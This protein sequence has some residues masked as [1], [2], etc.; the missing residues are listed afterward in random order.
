MRRPQL[1]GFLALV[2]CAFAALHAAPKK[3]ITAAALNHSPLSQH[4]RALHALNR[5]TFGPRPEDVRQV[6]A[7]GVDKWIDLQLHPERINDNELQTMLSQLPAMQLSEA[8]MIEKFPPNPMAR[9]MEKTNASLPRDPIEHAI[10]ANQIAYIK[11]NQLQQAAARASETQTAT[12]PPIVRNGMAMEQENKAAAQPS[13][14]GPS[15]E[16]INAL[17]ADKQRLRSLPPQARFDALLAVTPGEPRRLFQQ[18]K[19]PER[20][21]LVDGFTPEQKEIAI[22]LADTNRVV[23]G[24]TMEQKLLYDIYSERQLQEVVTDFWLNHFNVYVRKSGIEPWQIATYERDVIRPRALGKFEDLLRA[25]ATSPAMMEYLDNAQSIG[26]HSKAAG[27]VPKLNNAGLAKKLQGRGLNENYARELMELH[28]L[29]VNGGYTQQD[30]TEVAKVFTGWT[31][32]LPREGGSFQYM[33][34][35][36]EPG[37]KHVLGKTIRENGQ[38]EG[39]EV[40]HM[41][42]GSPATA[43]FLSRK[44]AVRFVSDNP[45]PALVDAMAQ[46]YLKSHGDIREVMKTMLQSPEFWSRDAY[47]AKVKTPLEYVVSSV[48]ATQT[49]ATHPQSLIASLNQMG[50]PLYGMQPPT[51]YSDMA[52]VW[53]NSAALL[54]RMNFGLALA[55][56]KLPGLHCDVNAIATGGS[57]DSR[58]EDPKVEEAKLED[59]LLNGSVSPKTHDTV[60]TEMEK[61]P[62]QEQAQDA[63]T[64]AD[65][66]LGGMA[67][68]KNGAGARNV[69]LNVSLSGVSES[70]VAAGLLLGSP[71]F[72]RK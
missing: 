67:A 12:T 54:T 24:E 42:A 63:P 11:A 35:R 13:P 34:R 66:L 43:H 10:Y 46:A 19:P 61:L 41:L 26:P 22:A 53:V 71:D 51:G 33:D 62:Q 72:Q 14:D 20:L 3:K 44:L 17:Q 50:M 47:R 21:A 1:A 27:F 7:M 5:L 40:L 69:N 23:A 45:P 70:A 32:A 29:G 2:V 49:D 4:E 64:D 37:D 9:N 15:P 65:P 30:V 52:D 25:V 55:S 28:T 18:I 8:R 60:L 39:F 16:E 57:P 31:I 38:Q 59:V 58:V 68:R 48:R 6:E 56:N 36:H